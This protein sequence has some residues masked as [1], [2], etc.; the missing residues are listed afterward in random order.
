MI[1][2]LG[3]NFVVNRWR[4][5]TINSL[6]RAGTDLRF[7]YLLIPGRYDVTKLS[8]ERGPKILTK[9]SSGIITHIT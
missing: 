8:S 9:S 3:V 7:L 5:I 2:R 6:L 4:T 1:W